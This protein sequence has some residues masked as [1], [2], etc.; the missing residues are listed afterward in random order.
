[1][2]KGKIWPMSLSKHKQLMSTS[3]RYMHASLAIK[4]KSKSIDKYIILN[5]Y[6]KFCLL[7]TEE[8][9]RES[10]KVKVRHTP[11]ENNSVWSSS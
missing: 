3:F 8:A 2:A 1:M 5:F 6:F 7:C 9:K 10:L 4:I 11:F